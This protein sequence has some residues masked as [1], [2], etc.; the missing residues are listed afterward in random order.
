MPLDLGLLALELRVRLEP[1]LLYRLRG[2]ELEAERLPGLAPR[3]ITDAVT[4]P[5]FA[6][7]PRLRAWMLTRK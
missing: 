7:R 1:R 2:F 6:E 5:D 3:E 4:P